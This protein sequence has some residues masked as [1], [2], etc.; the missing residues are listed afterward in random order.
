MNEFK[1]VIL[2]FAMLFIVGVIIIEYAREWNSIDGSVMITEWKID[3]NTKTIA[4]PI[5]GEINVNVD[6]G[7]GSITENITEEFPTH[8]YRNVG[9]YDIRVSGKIDTWGSFM[10]SYSDELKKEYIEKYRSCLI[11]V[12]QF[13][14]LEA[15]EYYFSNCSNLKYVNGEKVI[16]KKTFKNVTNMSS[17]FFKCESLEKINFKNFNVENVSDMTYM[18]LGCKNLKSL[19]F[20]NVKTSNVNKMI[21]MFSGCRSLVE[22]NLESFDTSNVV[23]MNKMFLNCD[24]LEN[25]NLKNF[26]TSKVENMESMFFECK[27]IKE[28]DLNSFTADSLTNC[29]NMFSNCSSL[30]KLNLKNFNL[31]TDVNTYG[32][33]SNS[34]L[35]KSE[36]VIGIDI[37]NFN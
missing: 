29:E 27:S 31:N 17:M 13:G 25:I 30:E 24:K 11:G 26:N 15:K 8:T 34:P 9:T 20:K 37:N 21:S 6:W 32:L 18:F 5:Q 28:L 10:V 2:V 14:E 23:S 12:K 3:E 35:L 33:F 22:L 16:T 7:D 4:L 1:K 36:N 19:N